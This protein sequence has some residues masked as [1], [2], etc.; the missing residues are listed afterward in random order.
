MKF[1]CDCGKII[2]DQTVYLPYK[3][4]IVSDQ[5]QEQMVSLMVQQLP[6]F[7]EA[8]KDKESFKK[9]VA[10]F[11]TD[12]YNNTASEEEFFKTVIWQIWGRYSERIIY[13]CNQCGAIFIEDIHN[14]TQ[15]L[16]CYKKT[17]NFASKNIL[18]GL[19]RNDFS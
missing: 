12:E 4:F 9:W 5:D 10:D 1:K 3:G 6:R 7:I 17:D 19:H 2:T 13:Q 14:R 18:E 15:Q 8:K 11:F 16:H